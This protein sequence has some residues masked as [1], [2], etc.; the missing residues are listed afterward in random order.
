MRQP[1]KAHVWKKMMGEGLIT[2]FPF[3]SEIDEAVS[4]AVWQEINGYG[5]QLPRKNVEYRRCSDGT[6]INITLQHTD[7]FIDPKR[8]MDRINKL[9]VRTKFKTCRIHGMDKQIFLSFNTR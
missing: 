9:F 5:I 2:E 7:F 4:R 8:V 1:L 6:E 3:D